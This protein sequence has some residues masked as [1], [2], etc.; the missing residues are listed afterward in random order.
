[1]I[2]NEILRD[3]SPSGDPKKE[4]NPSREAAIPYKDPL[5]VNLAIQVSYSIDDSATYEREV[6]GMVKFLKAYK[7]YRG[8]IV[9]WDTERQITEDGITIDVV[10]VWKWLSCSKSKEE[11]F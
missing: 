2:L 8:I 4:P 1:M 3:F 6:G 11:Y 9:A 10:P 7:Q 5:E